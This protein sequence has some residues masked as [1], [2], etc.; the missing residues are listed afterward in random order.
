MVVNITEGGGV[1][2]ACQG[3][4]FVSPYSAALLLDSAYIS[5]KFIQIMFPLLSSGSPPFKETL[6]WLQ[7]ACTADRTGAYVAPAS[8][9]LVH[10]TVLEEDPLF[11]GI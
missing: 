6:D 11:P 2:L 1:N 8:M 9:V 5:A 7:F 3:L 10:S 4:T